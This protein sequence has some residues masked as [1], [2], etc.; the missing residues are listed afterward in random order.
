MEHY[1]A[2]KDP[3]VV[4]PRN[5]PNGPIHEAGWRVIGSTTGPSASEDHV[6]AAIENTNGPLY[7][8][9]HPNELESIQKT[10]EAIDALRTPLMRTDTVSDIGALAI[11]FILD[12]YSEQYPHRRP[13]RHDRAISRIESAA[14]VRD[15]AIELLDGSTDQDGRY[16]NEVREI[17][18]NGSLVGIPITEVLG[19]SIPGDENKKLL[20]LLEIY[21]QN[22]DVAR[23]IVKNRVAGFHV[24]NSGALVDIITQGGLQTAFELTKQGILL[25]GGEREYAPAEGSNSIHFADWRS[26]DSI[27]QYVDQV[28]EP[29]SGLKDLLYDIDK[30][31][32][33]YDELL[34]AQGSNYPYT[35]AA[36]AIVRDKQRLLEKIRNGKE[37][38]DKVD[39]LLENFPIAFGV[40]VDGL[41]VNDI[42]LQGYSG[43]TLVKTSRSG[44]NGEFLV[45][46]GPTQFDRLPVMGVPAIYIP[47]VRRM[48]DAYAKN[49]QPL[50]KIVDI[51]SIFS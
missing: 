46:G 41:P 21:G 12:N 11:G 4:V 6:I 25:S 24:T 32:K 28:G 47:W 20:R 9:F 48:F 31:K 42:D 45:A 23:T 33:K 34:A 13:N 15:K 51:K 17:A 27:K 38:P 3:H 36:E 16:E 18:T 26:P 1:Q 35:Q 49:D 37:N 40:S 44:V 39:L 5:T 7:K 19:K 2:Y 43:P 29:R 22:P 30:T 10:N 8:V 50:P 14:A